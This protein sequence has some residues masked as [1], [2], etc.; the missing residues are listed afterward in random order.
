MSLLPL[1]LLGGCDR[2]D[3]A[4]VTDTNQFS[5][6]STLSCTPV[7]A[8]A[9]A[10]VCLDWSGLTQDI[11]GHAVDEG[12]T[13]V[14]LV[15]FRDLSWTEI[16]DGLT[17]DSLTQA[18]VGLYVECEPSGASCCLDEFEIF[19]SSEAI[20]EQFKEGSGNWLFS[21]TTEGVHGSRTLACLEPMDDSETVLVE[22]GDDSAS[23]ELDVDLGA[24]QPVLVST[25]PELELDWSGLSIDG[26]GNELTHDR[27]DRVEL[28][29]YEL[30]AQELGE[31][32]FDLRELATGS[33]ALDISG[34][35][36]VKLS[37]LEGDSAFLGV[38]ADSTWLAVL[39]CSSCENPVPKAV[40]VLEPEG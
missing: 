35:T 27:I 14:D 24:G 5:Y 31:Q 3:T 21:L 16:L 40:F 8:Q 26:L 18:E 17:E 29:S 15:L 34:R 33:W 38:D 28:A 30:P 11:Q 25:S 23:L 9:Q 10:D 20:S 19:G 22:V 37:E 7:Q 6:T 39:W 12:I 1:I 32:F 2:A 4:Q 36:S 13:Q